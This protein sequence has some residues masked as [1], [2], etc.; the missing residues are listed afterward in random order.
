MELTKAIKSLRENDALLFSS[1]Q[2]KVKRLGGWTATDVE[3]NLKG[4]ILTGN[5]AL[6][7]TTFWEIQDGLAQLRQYKVCN[8]GVV[9]FSALT[10]D[11]SDK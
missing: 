8:S 10:M 5:I 6:L 1:L 2:V 7:S 11:H 4:G 3:Q 9:I